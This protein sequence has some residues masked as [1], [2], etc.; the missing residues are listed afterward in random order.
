[1]R[2]TS[3]GADGVSL[4]PDPNPLRLRPVQIPTRIRIRAAAPPEAPH[5]PQVV[6]ALG[7]V[8]NQLILQAV[9]QV[10]LILVRVPVVAALLDAEKALRPRRIHLPGNDES[11][12]KAR[13]TMSGEGGPAVEVIEAPLGMLPP[14]T[15][16]VLSPELD[17]A[18]QR[19]LYNIERSEGI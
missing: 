4:P 3:P 5:H 7:L 14:N 16:F 8:R 1:M 13:R 11:T 12:G 17:I 9:D 15:P 18:M 19:G 2:V 10:A 6:L